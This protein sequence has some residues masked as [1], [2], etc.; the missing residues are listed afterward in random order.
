MLGEGEEFGVVSHN[1]YLRHALC[2]RQRGLNRIGQSTLQSVSQHQ[3]IHHHGDVVHLVSRQPQLGQPLLVHARHLC[4]IVNLA[5]NEHPREAVVRQLLQQGV[6]CALASPH[7]RRQHLKASAFRQG[8]NPIHYLLRRLA[9]KL[10]SRLGIVR[11]P[12]AGEQQPQIVIHLGNRADSG[13]RIPRGGF[14]VNGNRRRQPLNEIH[15]GLV[16]LPQEL[17]SIRRQ[18]LHIPPLPLRIN[19]VKRQ[20]RLP[21]PRNPRQHDHP[22]PRQIHRDI[23]QVVLPRPPHHKSLSHPFQ[24]NPKPASAE[25][26]TRNPAVL[27]MPEDCWHGS[28]IPVYR[29]RPFLPSF[30]V[31]TP[32][33]GLPYHE[34]TL[35]PEMLKERL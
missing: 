24:A 8:E 21:R 15:I 26:S 19:R 2:Q 35:R 13:A 20:R 17:P 29:V 34:I 1:L 16:H 32:L 5:V 6:I 4:Q 30:W 22:I 25:T 7:H 31:F 23:I 12:D 9:D 18:R 27:G 14:L 33:R 3:P 28:L 11:H 10:L